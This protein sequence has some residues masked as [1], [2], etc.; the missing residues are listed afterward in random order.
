MKQK[1]FNIAL[2][3]SE[4]KQARQLAKKHKISMAEVFR[5]GLSLLAQKKA[6][7]QSTQVVIQGAGTEGR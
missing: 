5:Q 3:E 1:L 4:H 2:S 6:V 7:I